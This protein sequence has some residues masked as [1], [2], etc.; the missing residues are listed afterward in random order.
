MTDIIKDK[1]GKKFIFVSNFQNGM[2]ANKIKIY[3]EQGTFLKKKNPWDL[4]KRYWN[5]MIPD[6]EA[7]RL[8]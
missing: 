2:P 4:K 6:L 8:Y 7:F 5:D 1:D 3:D